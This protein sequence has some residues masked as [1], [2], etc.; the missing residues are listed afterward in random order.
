MFACSHFPAQHLHRQKL[1]VRSTNAFGHSRRT[2]TDVF[3]HS[4][5]CAYVVFCLWKTATIN[6]QRRSIFLAATM[7]RSLF[8]ITL[9]LLALGSSWAFTSLPRSVSTA[10]MQTSTAVYLNN[11]FGNKA[12]DKKAKK[13]EAPKEE[14][15]KKP[16]VMMF[17]K[18]RLTRWLP[19]RTSCLLL[20]SV[21]PSPSSRSFT[22]CRTRP[23]ESWLLTNTSFITS[24]G[25][26]QYD[27]VKGREVR[28]GE[29]SRKQNW[30][31]KAGETKNKKK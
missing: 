8:A 7:M 29:N 24:T 22:S 26:P 4:K 12:N 25:K 28:P 21:M 17:G 15:K 31:Y 3:L 11:F 16:M 6:H 10:P 9:V 30:L 2:T 5:E 1:Q 23:S 18:T 27:W 19:E 14:K 13:K 20:H